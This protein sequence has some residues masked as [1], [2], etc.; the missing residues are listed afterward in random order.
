MRLTE[1]D[2]RWVG[3]GGEG[4]YSRTGRLCTACNGENAGECPRCHGDGFEYAPMP[5]RHGVGVSFLCT[6]PTCTAQRTGNPDEDFYLRV[7]VSL[8][9]PLDGGPSHDPRP[10]AQWRRT[11]DTFEALTLRPSILRTSACGW[12]G[13]VTEG[14]VLTC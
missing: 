13:F 9:N 4:V 5:A 2:P 11:G 8:A 10:G 1:L 6:C 3:A 14:E 12:H 7:F